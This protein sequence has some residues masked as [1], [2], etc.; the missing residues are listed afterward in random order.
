MA[1]WTQQETDLLLV[2]YPE[3][4]NE[5]CSQFLHRSQR[6]C[7]QK[8]MKL[9][10]TKTPEF[11]KQQKERNQFK[12]GHV[13]FNKGKKWEQF[14]S[15]EGMLNAAKNQ[16]KGTPHNTRHP[17]YEMLRA[18]HKGKRYWW[19]KPDDGRKMMPKH[20]WLWEKAH[21]PIPKGYNVQFKD[22]NPLNCVLEN[23]YLIPRDKQMRENFNRL[24]DE[25]KAAM[26]RKI[27]KSRNESIRRDRIR[28]KWGLAPKT[29]IK[30]RYGN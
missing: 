1:L 4:S 9:G 11:A 8:A 29:K 26:W 20:R 30:F 25:E 5:Y 27:T 10:I 14:M 3:H 19:I 18:A 28:I 7:Q 6:A 15:K 12:K 17:G 16:F 21:G 13:P 23:L 24:S 2:I 22:G